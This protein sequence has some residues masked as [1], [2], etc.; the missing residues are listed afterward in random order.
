M[1][2]DACEATNLRGEQSHEVLDLKMS[3]L[4]DRLSELRAFSDVLVE[5]DVVAERN[6]IA[7]AAALTPIEV[8][9]EITS[10]GSMIAPP[11]DPQMR[12]RVD[13]L[14]GRL[15]EVKALQDAGR[16]AQALEQVT[17]VVADAR[18]AGYE[19]VMAEALNRMA[20]LL[21]DTG[22]TRDAH[23]T[24]EEALW[25]AE[26]S[27]HD[28]LVVELATVEIY[29]SGY[30]EHDMVKAQRWINQARVFLKRIGG[31]D[32]LHAWVLN[33][34]GVALDANG[35]KVAAADALAEIAA[36]QAKRILGKESPQTWRSRS[37]TWPEHAELD[38]AHEGSAGAGAI[39][40]S[41][42][43][44]VRSAKRATRGWSAQLANRAVRS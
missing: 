22:R 21:V 19:P 5:G 14:R 26:G 30:L 40:A 32:L 17:S 43:W 27:R 20:L 3:C 15:V 13:A 24:I 2:K 11:S 18:E 7:A 37:P 44:D 9:G 28:E 23:A 4:R 12:Q 6:A 16:Y 35:D 34:I 29:I 10:V 39:V 1:Y 33:N 8:C 38:R 25:L 41:R 36:H 31:H 42:S